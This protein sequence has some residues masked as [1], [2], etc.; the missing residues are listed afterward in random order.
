MVRI[1]LSC[2]RRLS[3]GDDA[4][5]I[6]GVGIISSYQ[7]NHA[8]APEWG[9]CFCI[10]LAHHLT[11]ERICRRTLI[12]RSHSCGEPM[13]VC[14]VIAKG[15]KGDGVQGVPAHALDKFGTLASTPIPRFDGNV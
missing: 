3:T 4:G 13:S 2:D 8:A 10:N 14:S 5:F 15:L 1:H 6:D 7:S 12:A 9:S 11:P